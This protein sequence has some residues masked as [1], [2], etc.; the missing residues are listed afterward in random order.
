MTSVRGERSSGCLNHWD[1][2]KEYYMYSYYSK[3]TYP[4]M[5][6]W[7][8]KTFCDTLYRSFF[9]TKET[10]YLLTEGFNICTNDGPYCERSYK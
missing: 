1:G 3:E 10:Y 2:S 8:I 6:I 7:D 4:K 5:G 9:I